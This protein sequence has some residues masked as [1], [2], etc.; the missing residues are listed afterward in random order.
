MREAHN[1][2]VFWF[3]ICAHTADGVSCESFVC[4]LNELLVTSYFM[5]ILRSHIIV[6]VYHQYY[7]LK[8][9]DLDD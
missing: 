1:S 5:V 8:T 2:R 4:A 6:L 3:G 7:H 9:R